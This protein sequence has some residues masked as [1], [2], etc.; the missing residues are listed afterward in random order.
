[1]APAMLAVAIAASVV[2]FLVFTKTQWY[3][4]IGPT[5]GVLKKR[6]TSRQSKDVAMSTSEV[7]V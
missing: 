7:S 1:M 2:I 6:R 3:S 4:C 5:V